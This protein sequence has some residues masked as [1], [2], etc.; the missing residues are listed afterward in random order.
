MS[1]RERL[2]NIVEQVDGAIGALIMGY[3]GIPIDECILPDVSLDVQLLAVE[4]A[5]LLKEI[6]RTVDVLKTGGME[7]VSISTGELRVVIRA[8]NEEFFLV[9]LMVKD[10]NFGLGRYL[11]RLNA[12]VFREMLQD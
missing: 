8:L 10:G 3:D 12:S 6:K 11:L 1:F 7:E 9:L 5:T 4:Y 2:K